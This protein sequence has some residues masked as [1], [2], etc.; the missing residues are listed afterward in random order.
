M[1]RT[2]LRHAVALA[3]V[4]IPAVRATTVPRL[5]FEQLTDASEV[6]AS[7]EVTQSWA[8]WDNEHKYI[9]THYRL[10]VADTAKGARVSSLEFAE[11][12]GALGDVSMMIPGT[13]RYSTG[14]RVTVFLAR[15]PNGYLRTTGWAQGKYT[16]DEKGLLQSHAAIGLD[17]VDAKIPARG[18]SLQRLD[19]MSFADLKQRIAAHVRA[20][21][22]SV[23]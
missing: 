8:A 1:C 11:P 13:V 23:K 14:D 16:V 2:V 17:T 19:G 3:I 22:G 5:S 18:I 12:G 10:N 4:L 6:I 20:N 15:M 21:A 9:W 7:G